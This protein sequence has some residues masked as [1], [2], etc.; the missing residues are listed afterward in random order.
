MEGGTTR[1]T[2]RERG[3]WHGAAPK[4]AGRGAPEVSRLAEE[5]LERLDEHALQ[6]TSTSSSPTGA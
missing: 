3:T 5:A 2:R 1:D 6:N 4:G